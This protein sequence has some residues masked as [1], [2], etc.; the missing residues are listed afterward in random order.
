MGMACH[1]KGRAQA[2]GHHRRH[3]MMWVV[4]Q[5]IRLCSFQ[6]VIC[7]YSAFFI[8]GIGTGTP[9]PTPS[10]ALPASGLARRR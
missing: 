3:F 1:G 5:L 4:I 2:L 9:S 6:C 10:L 8:F 7:R